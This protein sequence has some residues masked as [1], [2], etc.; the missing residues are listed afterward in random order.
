MN[1]GIWA[2]LIGILLLL[3]ALSGSVLSRLPLSTSMLYLGVG[4]A[5]SPWWFGLLYID[6]PSSAVAIERT[7]EIVMLISLFSSGLKLSAGVGDRRW[8]HSVRLAVVSMILTVA[9]ISLIGVGLLGLSLGAAILLGGILAPTDPV[10]ASD[11]QV[12]SAADRDQLRFAL[13][14]E[15]GLNDG[16]AFPVVALGLGLLGL[17][18]LGP[19]GNQW[20][21]VD[22]I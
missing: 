21:L 16:T 7:A 2:T 12:A 8:L 5:L 14:G 4:A 10:L 9:A 11:V 19:L 3:M 15:G 6:L 13:T 18:E 17:H 20:I 22:V 1:I